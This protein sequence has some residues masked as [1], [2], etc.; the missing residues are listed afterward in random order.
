MHDCDC[1]HIHPD[2]AAHECDDQLP[3]FSSAGRGIKGDSFIVR[4]SDPDD[5][6]QTYLEGLSYDEA[7]KE[8]HSEWISENI[9]GGELSY[10]YNLRP[11]NDPQTFTITFIYKRPGRCEW[12]WTTPAIPYLLS[13]TGD[14]DDGDGWTD[15][16]NFIGSGVATIFVR[17]GLNKEWKEVLHYPEGTTRED[18]NAPLPLEPWSAT[19]TFGHGGDIEIPSFE[20]LA[21]IIGITEQDIFNI[22]E[23][24][25]FNFNGIEAQNLL[26]YIDKCDKRDLDHIHKDLG[27]NESGHPG[28]GAFGGEDTVKDY[29]DK[30]IDHLHKDMGINNRNHGNEAFDGEDDLKKW[31]EKKLKDALDNFEGC[32]CVGGNWGTLQGSGT[33]QLGTWSTISELSGASALRQ[34][35]GKDCG[36]LTWAYYVNTNDK[37][38]T[39]EIMWST[40]DSIPIPF[41]YS[42]NQTTS[43]VQ[44]GVQTQ[45]WGSYVIP[46]LEIPMD[47]T[48]NWSVIDSLGLGVVGSTG[49]TPQLV[50]PL[51][52][53]GPSGKWGQNN[54][55]QELALSVDQTYSTSNT[56]N[57]RLHG[58]DFHNGSSPDYNTYHAQKWAI[59]KYFTFYYDDH[60]V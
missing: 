35:D 40:T 56:R 28:S 8:F 46:N 33:V 4:I 12:S 54:M 23:G 38:C 58:A 25:T 52:I 34:Y 7:T 50:H 42:K 22:L 21:K 2:R 49:A 36:T 16:D 60:T 10:Q 29:I 24:N 14:D 55:R 3:A 17:A 15:M 31:V 41:G 19:I 20:D 53:N 39:V 27:F 1:N 48:P 47:Y 6:T 26:D 11:F 37:T 32:K 57:V 45:N 44:T 9:N 59:H 18:F 43:D 5:C 13:K 51:M 30:W